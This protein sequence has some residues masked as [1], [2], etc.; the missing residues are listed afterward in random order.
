MGNEDGTSSPS[1]SV[2]MK[3]LEDLKESL[4]SSMDTQLSELRAMMMQLLQGQ[5][6]TGPTVCPEDPKV[7]EDASK[8]KADNA[9]SLPEE[10]QDGENSSSSNP[11]PMGNQ[12]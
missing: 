1:A 12:T 6:A 4:T 11:K 2:S 7:A 3:D 9:P 10:I 8:A 5:K